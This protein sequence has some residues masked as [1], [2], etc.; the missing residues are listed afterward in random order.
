MVENEKIKERSSIVSKLSPEVLIGFTTLL[1][2]FATL[3]F[4]GIG[5][6]QWNSQIKEIKIRI[7]GLD[8]KLDSRLGEERKYFTEGM[9]R[10]SDKIDSLS[11]KIGA[12]QVDFAQFEAQSEN[13]S[14]Y[15][16]SQFESSSSPMAERTTVEPQSR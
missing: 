16:A 6:L 10:L 5:A 15:T 12:L 9:N 4:L 14:R 13:F 3:L 8:A 1:I 7:D 11:D 2:G